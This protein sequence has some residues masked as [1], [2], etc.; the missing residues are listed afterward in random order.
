MTG[1]LIDIQVDISE[2]PEKT[3]QI[4]V[5]NL[6]CGQKV[7][8][9]EALK[10]CQYLLPHSQENRSFYLVEFPDGYQINKRCL[11]N[12][13]HRVSHDLYATRNDA[14]NA[15]TLE[16]VTWN[17]LRESPLTVATRINLEDRELLDKPLE[18]W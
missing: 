10:K 5:S 17:E 1:I 18:T 13:S 4:V 16:L 8:L 3:Q 15:Y 14:Y 12:G 9:F 7:D 11:H 2:L 6:T